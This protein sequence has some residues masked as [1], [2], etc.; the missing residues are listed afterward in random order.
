VVDSTGRSRIKE[1]FH[2]AAE[3]A[4]EDREGFLRQACGEDANLLAEVRRLLQA[5]KDTP[6]SFLESADEVAISVGQTLGHYRIEG[7]L[8][9]GGM[10]EVYRARD[11]QLDRSVALKVLPVS[12]ARDP[13]RLQ[14]FKR[15]AKALAALSHPN[16]VTVF[17]VDVD[18]SVPYLTMELVEGKPLSK[19]IPADGLSLDRF[20]ALAVPLADAL[21][22]AHDKSIIHRDLKPGNVMVDD[23]GRPKILDF[24][25]AK[26][27]PAALGPEAQTVAATETLETGTG[28]VL[29][30]IGYMSPE[31]VRG[32]ATDPRSDVFSL[33]LVLYEMATGRRAFDAATSPD[34]LSAILRDS[35]MPAEEVRPDL[36]RHVGRVIRHC[37]EKDPD[38]R[39]QS[40]KDVRNE[41]EDLAK[42]LETESILESR[43]D[44]PAAQVRGSRVHTALV[45][46]A[47][48]ALIL[49]LGIAY[50]VVRRGFDGPP[51]EA[52]P[53]IESLAVLPFDNLMN[54]PEQAYFVE[55][56]HEA[57]IT[58]LSKIGALRV[59]SRTSAMRYAESEKSLPEIAR[60][61]DVD[62]LIEGS[63]LRADGQVRITAQLIDGQT[64]E[65]LW[66]DS[67]D[68][69]LENVLAL[70]SDVAKEIA[71][72]IEVVLTPEQRAR[73]V[74]IHRVDPAAYEA[75]LRGTYAFNQFRAQGYRDAVE[76]LNKAIEIQP[77]YAEAYARLS[78]AHLLLG[79]F[80]IEDR[81]EQEALARRNAEKALELD[82]QS[83]TAYAV[84][85]WL[86]LY[87]HWDWPGAAERFERALELSPYD[88]Y[89][90]HGYG[91]YL[92]VM[93]Q[94]E[95]GL[96]YLKR[97]AQAD[98]LSPIVNAPIG[99][100]M[101]F[102]RRYDEAIAKARQLLE[103]NPN[104]PAVRGFLAESLWHQ[105]KLGQALEEYR[106]IWQ[107]DPEV[108]EALD[109]GTG[110]GPERA[111]G[112]MA[113]V[114]ENRA[115]EERWGPLPVAKYFALA[116]DVEAA[117]EWLERAYDKRVPQ[118]MLIKGRP[119]FDNLRGDPRF[120]DLV[121]RIGIPE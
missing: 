32:E 22:A 44:G 36:P 62:A 116:G 100:H 105:G 10:G 42:E 20:F 69:D 37:L 33:G 88:L 47:I 54:D 7:P 55:G 113:Q 57:L 89:A 51:A 87:F 63:V 121:R 86:Q 24:G 49:A 52:K 94:G 30:T 77:D 41:L 9:R 1:I 103:I 74:P 45:I 101:L 85:G 97:A 95:E 17:S 66:A 107:N 111:M 114:L 75:F 112:K 98:P 65:H 106:L 93:G 19:C 16:I 14:R 35:P 13:E 68:R 58:D 38:R 50:L 12:F 67:Y 60:E 3:L 72:E 28:V 73:L 29:G 108:L 83:S 76:H 21:A 78:G 119:T 110:E 40:A 5:A 8:G 26:T 90:S 64:D 120:D 109:E 104:Y 46:G 84:I 59:I 23:E 48:A 39:Y 6:D 81:Q 18:V 25:L 115:L 92:T 56:M 80:G 15:E 118:L 71:D 4:V 31:Q 2:Q 102:V 79:G 82:P 70:L 99:G 96:E 43:P 53:K 117:L 34:L 61:L 11:S 91:D 27:A